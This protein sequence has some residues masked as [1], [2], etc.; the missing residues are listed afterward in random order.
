MDYE[1]DLP[2]PPSVN[3]LRASVSGRLI[4][5][6]AGR[7]YYNAGAERMAELGLVGEGISSPVTISLVMHHK[8]NVRYDVSNYL[9]AY[10]DALVKC[11]FI[12]DDHLIEYAS[13]KKGE[14]TAGGSVKIKVEL[15]DQK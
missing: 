9:K 6:S 13:I 5:S 12:V 15:I 1:F 8:M 4:T 14:K 10:E 7:K 2:F 11:G 3:T